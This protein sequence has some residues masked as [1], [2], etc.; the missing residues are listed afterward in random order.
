MIKEQEALAEPVADPNAGSKSVSPVYSFAVAVSQISHTY[1]LPTRMTSPF[2][3][4]SS[5]GL[6]GSSAGS[7]RQQSKC[8]LG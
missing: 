5:L 7:D 4:V 6:T 8:Q 3:C 2:P 1:Q